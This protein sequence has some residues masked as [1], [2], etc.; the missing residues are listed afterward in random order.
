M[1]QQQSG[2]QQTTISS[3]VRQRDHQQVHL[4]CL[5]ANNTV[6]LLL[7]G[8]MCNAT[9]PRGWA[10]KPTHNTQ[11]ECYCLSI[12]RSNNTSVVNLKE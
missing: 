1:W 3:G 2:G 4:H 7:L 9:N 12:K 8:I 11:K 6:A 10:V 5:A